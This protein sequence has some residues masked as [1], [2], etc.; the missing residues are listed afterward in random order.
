MPLL[1]QDPW[2]WGTKVN[3]VGW[4]KA[5]ATPFSTQH[6]SLIIFPHL[7][8]GHEGG[9]EN[10]LREKN[11]YFVICC[12]KRNKGKGINAVFPFIPLFPINF[13]EFPL[14]PISFLSSTWNTGQ[15]TGMYYKCTMI[16]V[17]IYACTLKILLNGYIGTFFFMDYS[18]SCDL[19]CIVFP[20][21][22]V[23][24]PQAQECN[25]CLQ[26]EL[27]PEVDLLKIASLRTFGRFKDLGLGRDVD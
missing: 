8:S 4:W 1:A 7:W 26:D 12:L 9:R 6:I 13:L 21:N 3:Y 20:D 2:G 22:L 19:T 16:N 17:K 23:S 10:M 18:A 11:T 27:G 14:F 5:K 24:P 25:W 15:R